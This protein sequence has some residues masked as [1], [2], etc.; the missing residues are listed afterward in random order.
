MWYAIIKWVTI[1]KKV[2]STLSLFI[3]V[4]KV[5]HPVGNYMFKE[6]MPTHQIP[7]GDSHFGSFNLSPTQFLR[8]C[9]NSQFFKYTHIQNDI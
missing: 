3:Q 2:Y 4:I 9:R 1:K 8:S 6:D 5:Q 7:T